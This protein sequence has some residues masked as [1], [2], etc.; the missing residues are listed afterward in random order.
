MGDGCRT[1]C[2]DVLLSCA[3]ETCMVLLTNVT[4]I[5]SIRRGPQHAKNK[6]VL[7]QRSSELNLEK[8]AMCILLHPIFESFE[9]WI[10]EY[11]RCKDSMSFIHLPVS[12]L[13]KEQGHKL[14]LNLYFFFF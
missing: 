13:L 10:T 1:Q 5:S 2:A 12:S 14:Q 8:R 6:D 3:V 9:V 11:S 4:P 7:N